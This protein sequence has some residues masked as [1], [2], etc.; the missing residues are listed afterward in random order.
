MERSTSSM[1]SRLSYARALRAIG[2]SLE[3][4]ATKNFDLA[5]LETGFVVRENERRYLNGSSWRRTLRRLG[6]RRALDLSDLHYSTDDIIRL[7]QSGKEMRRTPAQTPDF[8]LLSQLLRSVGGAIDRRGLRLVELNRRGSKL[9]LRLEQP[10]GG[11]VIE[12]HAISSFHNTFLGMFFER[13]RKA[14]AGNVK[15]T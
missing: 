14:S 11:S 10:Q 13:R 15:D 8:Y 6:I 9:I 12:E 4:Q 1:S 2:Q 3:A 5:N 7:E